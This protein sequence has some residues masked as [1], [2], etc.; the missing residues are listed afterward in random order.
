M[1]G[2]NDNHDI[3]QRY[4]SDA[5]FAAI[6][7]QQSAQGHTHATAGLG[8]CRQCVARGGGLGSLQ[9]DALQGTGLAVMLK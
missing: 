4:Q 2:L 7:L 8:L 1:W 6:M 9:K 5:L 3:F